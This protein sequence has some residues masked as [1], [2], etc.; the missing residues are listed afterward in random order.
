[1]RH[2]S[3]VCVGRNLCFTKIS[4]TAD[5]DLVLGGTSTQLPNSA[6]ENWCLCRLTWVCVRLMFKRTGHNSFSQSFTEIKYS[7]QKHFCVL[8]P[9]PFLFTGNGV[10]ITQD[11]DLK[12]HV[13]LLPAEPFS[14]R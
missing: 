8:P 4:I 6:V 10:L 7:L 3:S 11:L 1:M 13:F 12:L 5:L 14:M 9:L 2:N